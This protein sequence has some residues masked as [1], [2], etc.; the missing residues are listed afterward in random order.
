M[1]AE[2][3]VLPGMEDREIEAL[4]EKAL[5]Y[6]KLRDRRMGLLEKEVAVKAEL[7][8]MMKQ[9]HKERYSH[10]GITITVEEEETVK[11]KVRQKDE[12]GE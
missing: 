2:T 10:D 4:E 9:R 6:A 12:E 5:E 3:K 7:L 1:P 11:V 8:S